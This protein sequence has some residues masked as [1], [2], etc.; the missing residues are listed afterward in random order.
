MIES[1]IIYAN[2]SIPSHAALPYTGDALL[3][4]AIQKFLA[5]IPE[6]PQPEVLWSLKYTKQYTFPNLIDF[7]VGKPPPGSSSQIILLPDLSPNLAVEDSLLDNVKKAWEKIVGEEKG[8]GFMVFED[9]EGLSDD[10]G[11]IDDVN[12][13]DEDL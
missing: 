7:K 2:T 6:D 3:S 8:D 10:E 13:R 9:R 11:D 1:G 5:T 12:G 4:K